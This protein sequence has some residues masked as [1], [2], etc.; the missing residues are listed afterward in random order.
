MIKADDG[1]VWPISE[2]D[3]AE[4]GPAGMS[5]TR[6]YT[7]R[8]LAHAREGVKTHALVADLR[9]APGTRIGTSMKSRRLCVGEGHRVCR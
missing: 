2:T 1:A 6:T 7:T 4:G 9:R 8:Y 5:P 3:S